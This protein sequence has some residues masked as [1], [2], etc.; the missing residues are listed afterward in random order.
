[1]SVT[2]KYKRKKRNIRKTRSILKK[3]RKTRKK[4]KK[5]GGAAQVS[6]DNSITVLYKLAEGGLGRKKKV[7]LKIEKND[8]VMTVDGEVSKTH[9]TQNTLVKSDDNSKLILMLKT[10]QSPRGRVVT[11]ID[12]GV[13]NH[14]MQNF[15]NE[16][17]RK[18]SNLKKCEGETQ[19]IW[20]DRNKKISICIET[21]EN[22]GLGPVII[23]QELDAAGWNINTMST[24]VS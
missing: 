24:M 4:M 15:K 9:I 6:P 12:L 13:N 11:F 8:V 22:D 21:L 14:Q 7:K 19:C 5:I 18:I 1:M 17:F 2:K 10:K 23:V 20:G 3:K 16:L